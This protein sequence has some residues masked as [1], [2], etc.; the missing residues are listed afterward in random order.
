MLHIGLIGHGP[1]DLGI[2]HP[3][4]SEGYKLKIDLMKFINSKAREFE[5]INCHS[6]MDLGASTI[7]SSAIT[8]M[9]L[10]IPEQLIFTADLHMETPFVFFEDKSDVDSWH[11]DIAHVD[12]VNVHSQIDKSFGNTTAP[13]ETYN[14]KEVEDATNKR[15]KN[16]IDACDCILAVHDGSAGIINDC[17]RYA[18]RLGKEVVVLPPILYIE[19]EDRGLHPWS[20]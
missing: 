6:N 16:M 19:K 10:L 4:S 2:D 12:T 17:I 1:E 13:V 7:W 3:D 18:R 8:E 20:V 11:Y 15:N 9:K 14:I 5:T